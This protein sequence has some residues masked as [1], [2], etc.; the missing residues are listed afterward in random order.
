MRTDVA[1][2]G[3]LDPIA[4]IDERHDVALFLDFDGTLVEIAERPGDVAPSKGLVALWPSAQVLACSESFDCEPVGIC[5]AT[6]CGEGARLD[7]T[8]GAAKF[9]VD[10]IW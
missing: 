3:R 5:H 2:A 9:A 4:W 8:A 6:Q 10:A 1:V 7:P